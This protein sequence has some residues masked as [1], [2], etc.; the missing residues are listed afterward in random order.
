MAVFLVIFELADV[1]VTI[2]K[3]DFKGPVPFVILELADVSVA[4]CKGKGTLSVK[5]VIFELA[6]VCIAIGIGV[7]AK[8]VMIPFR[9]IR[10]TVWQGKTYGWN[11]QESQYN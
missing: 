8:T 10:G 9:L 6:D 4:I 3:R 1:S 7:C 5:G 11:P 2:C